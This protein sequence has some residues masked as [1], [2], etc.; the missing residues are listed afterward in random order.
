MYYFDL[1]TRKVGFLEG[2]IKC[3]ESWILECHSAE[4]HIVWVRL[5]TLDM[6]VFFL[7]IYLRS[8]E[9]H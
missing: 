4:H 8:Q 1:N 5:Q 6:R 3:Q 2:R 7:D 9:K